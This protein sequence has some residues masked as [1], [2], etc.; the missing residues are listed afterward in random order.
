MIRITKWICKG[1]EP[2]RCCLTRLPNNG[3]SIGAIRGHL[4]IEYLIAFR[5]DHAGKW[6]AHLMRAAQGPY[7]PNIF[8]ANRHL[9]ETKLLW[10]ADHARA[11]HAT[12]LRFLHR[13]RL[14]TMPT[15]PGSNGGNGHPL[16]FRHIRPATDNL[17][18]PFPAN[19]HMAHAQFVGIRVR[20]Y[21]FNTPK[22]NARKKGILWQAMLNR[23][24]YERHPFRQHI[25]RF[26]GV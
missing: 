11:L 5:T 4:N 21:A 3:H 10:G 23:I 15:H 18:K 13:Y 6:C 12:H 9:A 1:A 7:I 24:A 2:R 19:I 17:L 25:G 20:C 26:V 8:W 14:T 16:A 22:H